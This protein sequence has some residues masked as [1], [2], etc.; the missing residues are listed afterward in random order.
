M[1]SIQPYSLKN[2]PPKK[3]EFEDLKNSIPPRFFGSRK[4]N[5]RD[6]LIR[7]LFMTQS[8]SLHKFRH[9]L[10]T[11]LKK[12]GIDDALIQPYSGHASR[13]SLEVYSKLVITD[14]QDEYKVSSL[15]FPYKYERLENHMG[16][17]VVFPFN[18][19]MAPN[20]PDA[21]STSL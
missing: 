18:R 11:W 7:I 21:P 12:Q 16:S 2:N 8:I 10:L 9:F 20:L 13:K 14:A 4:P 17:Q 15:K 3:D 19:L 1:I 5:L 6:F